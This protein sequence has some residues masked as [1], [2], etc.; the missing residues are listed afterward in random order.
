MKRKLKILLS[1]I[2]ISQLFLMTVYAKPDWPSDTDI[3]AESG[4]V[5]DADSGAVIFGK[6]MHNAYPPASITKILTALIVLE[7]A[8]PD[9]M[10]T[11]SKDSIY[12]VEAGSGNKLNVTN[13]DKLSVEDCLYSLILHSCNQAANA[14]AEHVAGSREGFVEMMNKKIE[15]LGCTESHFDNPSGLNGDTQY[16]TAYDMAIIAKAAYSNKKLVEISSALSHDIPP[17]TNNPEGL[18]IYNE[19]RLVKT[20]DSAS[21]FYFPSA[22]A[23]KTGYLIK[24]GNTLV[25]YAEQDGRR[26]ISVILKGSPKQYFIDGK[27]L[28]QFGYDRFQ[29]VALSG[30]E[31]DYT[32][33][34]DPV[35]IGETS[36]KPSDLELEA[37]SVITLPKDGKFSD[38]DKSLLTEL[39]KNSPK[40][41]VALI[42]YT[43]NDRK[44]GQAYL[45]AKNGA[46][47]SSQ[48]TPENT[49]E[50]KT[51]EGK[52][53]APSTDAKKADGKGSGVV[54]A[55][56]AA[57]LLIVGAG[58][59][60][61]VYKRRKEF[62]QS[63]LRR[64]ERR[65]RLRAEGDNEAFERILKERR[66]T[67]GKK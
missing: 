31:T 4:I 58:A 29:N 43:Y 25:T 44:A 53:E 14:L 5:I 15:E 59:G 12:N 6:N 11:F 33:G 64:E 18:T 37:N 61:V 20:K 60:L 36:Y 67:K 3:Q 66:N 50:P 8:N 41:A 17:T 10:V 57:V 45:I 52:T 42:Q 27:N 56:I 63:E 47:Q 9:D 16:V 38:A 13:G 55:G 34:E 24:A 51:E 48:E 65:R 49:T 7:N 62:R 35:K 30:N 39:P 54:A 40:G 28:L 21:E 1:C 22:V 46:A 26:L 23:G 19:H 32:E 2:L